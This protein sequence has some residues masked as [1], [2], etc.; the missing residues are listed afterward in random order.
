MRASWRTPGVSFVYMCVYSDA[1][2]TLRHTG[3]DVG[4][5]GVHIRT[6]DSRSS[7]RPD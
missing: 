1:Y 6:R 7:E 4:G 5:A 3:A 2:Q